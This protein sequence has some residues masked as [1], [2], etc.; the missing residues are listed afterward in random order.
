MDRAGKF[1]PQGKRETKGEGN[2]LGG[3]RETTTKQGRRVCFFY[4]LIC[5]WRRGQRKK[6]CRGRKKGEI[7]T[8]GGKEKEVCM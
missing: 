6:K 3:R 4:S 2:K 1:L 8:E 5:F 7:L